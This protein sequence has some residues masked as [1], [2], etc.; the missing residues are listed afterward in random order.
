MVSPQN[1]DSKSPQ[2]LFLVK[3]CLLSTISTGESAG[4]LIEFR[5]KLATVHQGCIY[6][7]F[8]GNHLRPTFVDR[9][10]HNDFAVW[11][12]HT[13][14]DHILAERLSIIDPSDYKDL[15]DLRQ[16]LLDIVEDRL[17][18]KQ[19]FY[20]SKKQ[21]SFHFVSSKIIIFSTPLQ[22]ANPADLLKIIPQMSTHSVFY[23]FIDAKR[24]SNEGWDDFSVWLNSFGDEYHELIHRIQ[25]IDPYFFS[26]QELR[27]QLLKEVQDYFIKE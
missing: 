2:P 12:Y 16:V 9:E 19:S 4:T 20:W 25:S 1:I 6:H 17:D 21:E 18:E 10:Y 23:H 8:W 27:R 15:E 7:H 3:D 24:R 11:I 14:H 13:L 5:D 26:L 22:I